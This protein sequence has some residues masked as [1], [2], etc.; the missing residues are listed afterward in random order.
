VL[1]DSELVFVCVNCK[2]GTLSPDVAFNAADESFN[3]PSRDDAD[4]MDM[5]MDYMEPDINAVGDEEVV[6]NVSGVETSP[7]MSFDVAD[8]G[9]NCCNVSSKPNGSATA[10]LAGTVAQ[11][12]VVCQNSLYE[13]TAAASPG[14]SLHVP[15]DAITL[16]TSECMRLGDT[17]ANIQTV[18]QSTHEQLDSE[19]PVVIPCHKCSHNVL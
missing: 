4:D 19:E 14:T 11:Q 18:S 5:D 16:C 1:S 9:S 10:S 6:Q 2:I 17:D 7:H 13:V 12:T 3:V 8:V 15:F